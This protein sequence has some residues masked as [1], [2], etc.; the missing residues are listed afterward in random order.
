MCIKEAFI[1]YAAAVDFPKMDKT[2]YQP[3]YDLC[4]CGQGRSH[5]KLLRNYILSAEESLIIGCWEENRRIRPDVSLH[6]VVA[7]D[8]G[9]EE[10]LGLKQ[11]GRVRFLTLVK[12]NKKKHLSFTKFFQS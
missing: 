5:E 3:L 2:Q 4:L 1:V 9:L 6:E 7:F 8:L 12:N 11:G 10:L